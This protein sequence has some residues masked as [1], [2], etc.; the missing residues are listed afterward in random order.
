MLKLI[1]GSKAGRG[2][3]GF[4][5]NSRK[6]LIYIPVPVCILLCGYESLFV[7]NS[8]IEEHFQPSG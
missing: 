1:F 2:F 8:I 7:V 4:I 3:P 6:L 5:S